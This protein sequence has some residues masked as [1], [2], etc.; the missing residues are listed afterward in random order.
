MRRFSILLERA[1]P[2]GLRALAAS[3]ALAASPTLAPSPALAAGTPSREEAERAF[4][5]RY[6]IVIE[7]NIF[8]RDRPRR[9][10]RPWEVPREAEAPRPAEP[11]PEESHVLTGVVR[12]GRTYL[13]FVEDLRAQRTLKAKV[14]DPVAR[15]RIAA[16]TIDG[17]VYERDGER[18][19]VEVGRTLSGRPAS[20]ASAF[21]SRSGPP[22]RS[23]RA[24]P[25]SAPSL[26][27]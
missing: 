7:R 4:F 10:V 23:E 12:E 1:A 25:G 19:A 22:G 24:P 6:E 3:L 13:A 17:I 11:P 26:G 15:G 20:L 8:S 18:T 5:E 2:A 9:V 14:G 16:I 21:G 27:S